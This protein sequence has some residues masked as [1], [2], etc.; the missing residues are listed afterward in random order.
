MSAPHASHIVE[1]YLARLDAALRDV[2]P[3]RRREISE[4]VRAHIAEARAALA[5]E[6]DA[7]LLNLVDRLGDP[8]ELAREARDRVDAPPQLAAHREGWGWVEL[9]AIA[10]TVAAWPIG[11]L[12]VALSAIWRRREKT[13]A[14]GLGAVPFALGFPLLAPIV[15][16]LLGP[17]VQSLGGAAPIF[18]GTLGALPLL[19][20]AYLAVRLRGTPSLLTRPA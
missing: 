9:G 18:M 10:L 5:A 13:I 19:S 12:L 7:D 15:G 16:P 8:S 6:S 4:D 17:L 1:G 14:I 20:A 2:E 3:A 11:A